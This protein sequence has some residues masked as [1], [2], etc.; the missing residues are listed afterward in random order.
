MRA[1][2]ILL[3]AA[4]PGPAA[5]QKPDTT[6]LISS[7]DELTVRAVKP[8]TTVG[9]AS[10]FQ[11]RLDSLILPPAPTLEL[12]LREF[13]ALHVRRNSRGEAEI[14]VRGSESRQVAVLFD[15]IPL[16]L[17]WDARMDASVIPATAVQQLELTRGLSS[18]LHGPN[19]LGG[20][21]DIR[22]GSALLQPSTAT[23]QITAGVDRLGAFG[24]SGQVTLPQESRAGR[25]LIRGGGSFSDTP[26]LPLAKGVVE[27]IPGARDTRVNTDARSYDGFASLRFHSNSGAWFSAAGSTFQA[28]RGV[29]AELGNTAA[30]FWRYPKVTRTIG[31]VSGGTGDRK[32]LLGGHGDLEASL[33]IDLGRT[34]IDAYTGRD[35]TTIATFEN[36]TDRGVTVRLL[37]DHS[38]GSRGELR[39]S[40]T[41]S[42][43][44]HDDSLPTETARYRQ[45][46]TSLGAET[47]WRL[48]EDGRGINSFRLSVG[49]AYDVARTP[50]TGG[51][52]SFDKLS[53][54][55]GR[56]GF[57]MGVGAGATLVHGGVSRRARFPSLRELYSG[58]LNRFAPNPNLRAENLVAIEAG[59]TTRVGRG[60]VQLVGFRHQVNDAVVR[61]TLPAPDRRF[62]R[63]NLNR[64]RTAGLE[65]LATVPI[66]AVTLAGDL[67]LQSV[68]LSDTAGVK[69]APENIPKVF[70]RL[71]SRFPLPLDLI[72]G[73]DLSLTGSQFCI[74]PGSGA[75]TKLAGGVLV[76]TEL[77]RRWSLRPAGL[78]SRLE[79]RVSI[80][81]VGDR[82][83]YDQC[84]LPG[85]GRLLRLLLRVY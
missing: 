14:S 49:G 15:G 30:R 54:W 42:D 18:M 78:L 50:E 75:D 10:A 25:W 73:V 83:I 21:I 44:R 46:L 19:V 13:P 67:T 16:T 76:G 17:A 48:V 27:P 60:E 34:D 1:S 31:V 52:P 37:G 35:Y 84:G 68:D 33:G 3:L 55:G 24:T 79:T 20:V 38:L 77:G 61:T 51:R 39:T 53:E 63:V 69:R 85:P 5:A 32:A 23:A 7:L 43:I 8:I 6:K 72:G 22:V 28:E 26:G 57:T 29:A 59:V 4:L 56:V 2:I 65:L 58:A 12:V 47:I 40:Y 36:G 81:N 45:R 62:F 64:L 74:D 80:D 9:G 66:G 11:L 41:I 71:R 82:A 70:G